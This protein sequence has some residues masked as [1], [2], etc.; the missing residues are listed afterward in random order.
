MASGDK[1]EGSASHAEPGLDKERPLA[2]LVSRP[3]LVCASSLVF[4]PIT[5][6]RQTANFNLARVFASARHTSA[7]VSCDPAA[8]RV[9]LELFR[10]GA[11]G[12]VQEILKL[13]GFFE[14]G[15]EEAVGGA[16]AGNGAE[17]AGGVE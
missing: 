13:M 14:D 1:Q 4:G 7:K 17:V 15:G 12:P 9:R 16:R 6:N 3:L 8:R 11:E 5:A 10:Y 2:S